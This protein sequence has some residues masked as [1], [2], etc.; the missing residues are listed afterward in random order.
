MQ[1]CSLPC[2][3]KQY[4]EWKQYQGQMTDNY[5][6]TSRVLTQ[7]A[8]LQWTYLFSKLILLWHCIYCDKV[9]VFFSIW[10]IKYRE[11]AYRKKDSMKKFKKM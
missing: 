4:V 5:N 6:Y 9:P 2:L 3:D 8:F 10:K 7:D 11:Y 1:N